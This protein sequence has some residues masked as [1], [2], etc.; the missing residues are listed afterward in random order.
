MKFTNYN[1]LILEDINSI[2]N[3]QSLLNEYG[4]LNKKEQGNIILA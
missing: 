4:K 3:M 2:I 1:M